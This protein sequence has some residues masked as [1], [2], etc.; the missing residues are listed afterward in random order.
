M[1]RHAS[2]TIR[3]P[4]ASSLHSIYGIRA[5]EVTE[6]VGKTQLPI[7]FNSGANLVQIAERVLLV[8]QCLSCGMFKHQVHE[9]IWCAP[10]VHE[11]RPAGTVRGAGS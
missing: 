9:A 3:H 10:L 5:P 1:P 4:N 2:G 6:A 11:A 7:H 8:A